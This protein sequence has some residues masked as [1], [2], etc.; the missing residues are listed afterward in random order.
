MHGGPASPPRRSPRPASARS[1]PAAWCS[2]SRPRA[3]RSPEASDFWYDPAVPESDGKLPEE[4]AP[5]GPKLSRFPI[6]P[7]PPIRPRLFPD[8]LR[9]AVRLAVL[10]GAGELAAW[11][12]VGR[13]LV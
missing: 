12:G 11:A 13:A 3:R 1:S 5:R 6:Q 2:R 4:F 7:A 9:F 8:E 10:A